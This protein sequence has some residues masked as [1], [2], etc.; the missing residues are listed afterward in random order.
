MKVM[1]MKIPIQDKQKSFENSPEPEPPKQHSNPKKIG[2]VKSVDGTSDSNYARIGI[3]A[4]CDKDMCFKRCTK[5]MW[6]QS[7]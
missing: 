6:Y 1:L 3:L 7:L 2:S 5:M 4:P